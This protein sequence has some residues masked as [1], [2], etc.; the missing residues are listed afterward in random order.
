MSNSVSLSESSVPFI[1]SDSLSYSL[2]LKCSSHRSFLA[3][4]PSFL[5]QIISVTKE[6]SYQSP[7]QTKLDLKISG[8]SLPRKYFIYQQIFK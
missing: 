4:F 2:L 5:S 1:E 8:Q 7:I 3:H 6:F